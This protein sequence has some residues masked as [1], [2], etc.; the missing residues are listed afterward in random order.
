M[1]TSWK[2]PTFWPG[3]RTVC[4]CILY[5]FSLH[6]SYKD[7]RELCKTKV[8]LHVMLE[9]WQ[10]LNWVSFHSKLLFPYYPCTRFSWHSIFR[11]GERDQPKTSW[12]C[13][14]FFFNSKYRTCKCTLLQKIGTMTHVLNR[15]VFEQ[16]FVT[17]PRRP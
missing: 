9:M 4:N 1:R 2:S 8:V 17:W 15:H 10:K 16:I 5:K 7:I 3:F 11:G 6:Y 13:K 12:K 14:F